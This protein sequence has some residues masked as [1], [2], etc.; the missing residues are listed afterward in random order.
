MIENL[1]W[2]VIFGEPGR[3]MLLAGVAIT[4]QVFAYSFLL[5]TVLGLTVALGR[6]TASPV[7]APMRWVFTAY[8]E[9]F[10]NVPVVVQIAF[11]GFGVFSLGWVRAL[12][13]P[14]NGL[15]DD[16]FIAGV[17]ALS[18][19][20]STFIAEAFRGGLQSIDKGVME[21]ARASGLNYI[22]SRSHVVL[23]LMIR[24]SLPAVAAQYVSL[25]KNTTIVMFIGVS[26]VVFQTQEIEST[27]FAAFEAFTAAIV[28]ITVL[29]ILVAGAFAYWSRRLGSVYGRT[30]SVS[31]A[32]LD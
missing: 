23:P 17:L 9:F 12:F 11:W 15:Y 14:I 31:A 19:Y 32:A 20:Q 27:T 29:C 1:D 13:S 8:V 28:I 30:Q 26:E 25:M 24:Y 5:T 3:S 21:A 2:S 6:V 4:L 16:P 10:R 7:L 22:Q 18:V